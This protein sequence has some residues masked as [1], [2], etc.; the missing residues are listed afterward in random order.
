MSIDAL[1][2]DTRDRVIATE[3]EIEHLKKKVDDMDE[4]LGQLVDMLTQAKGA[5]RA[6][7]ILIFI[8]SSSFFAGLMTY[9]KQI[10]TFF[11][12]GLQ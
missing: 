7:Q 5:R 11:I 12:G 4:K 10:K 1:S 9:A 2:Q 3:K 6:I 8:S